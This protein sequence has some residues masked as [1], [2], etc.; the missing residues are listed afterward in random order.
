MENIC[1]AEEKSHSDQKAND[2][3]LR[4]ITPC[5]SQQAALLKIYDEEVLQ[6]QGEINQ[7]IRDF[8]A[9]Y[10]TLKLVVCDMSLQQLTTNDEKFKKVWDVAGIYPFF[11]KKPKDHVMLVPF[12]FDR[13]ED[14][15]GGSGLPM[16]ALVQ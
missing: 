13:A 16:K 6:L 5:N 7:K 12:L 14:G 11:S 2:D 9:R 4:H 1:V 3:N 15:S 10:E 8:E